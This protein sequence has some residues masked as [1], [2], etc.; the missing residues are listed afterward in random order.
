MNYLIQ[1]DEI[2]FTD[3]NCF[4]LYFYSDK[5]SHYKPYDFSKFFIPDAFKHVLLQNTFNTCKLH[6]ILALMVD[7]ASFLVKCINYENVMCIQK[8]Y[9]LQDSC[10]LGKSCK[11]LARMPLHPRI[12][13][14]C[15]CI[16][17]SCK[18]AIASKNLARMPLHPRILQECHCIQE[19]CKN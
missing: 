17:E 18:N 3:K 9:F 10:K 14:E 13:Q 4:N 5:L 1:T 11:I 15:Q 19:S 12:L 2:K 16:Q 7:Y 8:I 6:Q